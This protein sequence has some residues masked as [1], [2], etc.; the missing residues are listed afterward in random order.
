M[1]FEVTSKEKKNIFLKEKASGLS[2]FAIYSAMV[3]LEMAL[4]SER[5]GRARAG[6]ARAARLWSGPD[7]AP[8]AGAKSE[9]VLIQDR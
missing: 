6:V 8:V 9:A 7:S 5:V 3:G 1:F 4:S 2:L